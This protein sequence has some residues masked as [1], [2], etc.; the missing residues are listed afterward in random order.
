MIVTIIFVIVPVGSDEFVGNLR[1]QLFY[2]YGIGGF[3]KE[4]LR[5]YDNRG[6]IHKYYS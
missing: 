3:S 2:I 1:G 5:L 4:A 6:K